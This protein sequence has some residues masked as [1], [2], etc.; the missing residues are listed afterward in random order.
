MKLRQKQQGFIPVIVIVG[1]I[2]SGLLGG[3][4]GFQ[5]GDGTFFSFGIGFG[6][7]LVLAPLIL[8]YINRLTNMADSKNN[9]S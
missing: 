2:V 7:V 5:L 1:L 4:L 8:K 6:V 9:E 3:Y